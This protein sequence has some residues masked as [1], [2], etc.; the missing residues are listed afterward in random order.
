[1]S[2]LLGASGR[3]IRE[4]LIGTTALREPLRTRDHKKIR[5][6]SKCIRI[7]FEG[8]YEY[9]NKRAIRNVTNND[10]TASVV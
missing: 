8:R 7:Q 9:Q 4:G 3:D 1:M 10:K 5:F 6:F 2:S